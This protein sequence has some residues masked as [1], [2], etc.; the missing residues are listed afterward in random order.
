MPLGNTIDNPWIE[1]SKQNEKLDEI[2]SGYKK[3]WDEKNKAEKKLIA[4]DTSGNEKF[5][6][7]MSSTWIEEEISSKNSKDSAESYESNDENVDDFI[8]KLFDKAEEHINNKVEE[9]L[10]IL[11][12]EYLKAIDKR[13]KNKKVKNPKKDAKYLALVRDK[14]L[15]DIDEALNE[16]NK[17]DEEKIEGSPSKRFLAEIEKIKKENKSFMRGTS[18]EINPQS[19][20]DIKS[21]HLITAL[22]QAQGYDDADEDIM[23]DRVKANKINLIEAFKNDDIIN[24]FIEEAEEKDVKREVSNNLPGWGYWDGHNMKK[25]NKIEEKAQLHKR[26]DRII[27]SSTPNE[28]LRKHLI[29]S[30]PFPF[31]TVKDFEAA[32]RLPIGKDFIPKSAHSRLTIPSVVTKAGVPILPMTEDILVQSDN[33]NGMK[34]K[35]IFKRKIFKN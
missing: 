25:K 33:G 16:G 10:K 27:I 1:G 26:K 3:F 17:S 4:K 12:P 32:M 5:P 9:K 13:A 6:L 8:N 29:S 7:A 28:K 21:K 19:F 30:V 20:L 18:D 22:S 11:K 35:K 34:R 15:A 2:F 31:S 24:D 14:K 23:Q